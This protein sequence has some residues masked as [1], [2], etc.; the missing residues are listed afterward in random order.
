MTCNNNHADN[1]RPVRVMADNDDDLA[2]RVK[3]A[4]ERKA[5]HEAA[6]LRVYRAK[7]AASQMAQQE[8]QHQAARMRRGSHCRRR[9]RNRPW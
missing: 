2:E 5:Q 4:A 1:R 3:K 9:S 7:K 6:R 8:A